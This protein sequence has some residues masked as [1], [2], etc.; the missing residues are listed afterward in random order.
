MSPAPELVLSYLCRDGR[1]IMLGE[2]DTPAPTAMIRRSCIAAT[3]VGLEVCRYFGVPA[4]PVATRCSV[5]NA[6]MAAA[7]RAG[8]ELDVDELKAQGAWWLDSE[9]TGRV[10]E[11]AWDGHLV[12]LAGRPGAE[13][14]VDLSADQFT[15]PA[16]GIYVEP[17][18]VPHPGWPAVLVSPEG[19]HMSYEPLG[20]EAARSYQ[21]SPDWRRHERWRPIVAQ[22]IRRLRQLD[23][24]RVVPS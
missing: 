14:L 22:I 21:G 15:R 11:Q 17:Y 1:R 19:V 13:R 7:V 9:G 2:I 5:M 20:P 8:G 10:E 23:A 4:T 24:P 12:M 16:K 3:R 6:P 18:H